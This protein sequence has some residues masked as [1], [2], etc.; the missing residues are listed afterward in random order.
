MFSSNF[1]PSTKSNVNALLQFL[2]Y[3]YEHIIS[4]RAYGFHTFIL[5]NIYLFQLRYK[6]G[7]RESASNSREKKCMSSIH[8]VQLYYIISWSSSTWFTF[9][10]ANEK[11]WWRCCCCYATIRTLLLFLM[12]PHFTICCCCFCTIRREF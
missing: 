10:R 8:S 7:K 6:S 4:D 2:I 3:V 1:F 9:L 12:P 11:C 5:Y